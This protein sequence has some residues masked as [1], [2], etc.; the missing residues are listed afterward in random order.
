M[1]PGRVKMENLGVGVDARISATAPLDAD[2]PAEDLPQVLLDQILDRLAPF[3]TLPAMQRRAI[4]G[5]NALPAGELGLFD[6]GF[7]RWAQMEN[8]GITGPNPF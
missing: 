2:L 5:D 3:L 8:Q 1:H 6:H 4:I 7:H